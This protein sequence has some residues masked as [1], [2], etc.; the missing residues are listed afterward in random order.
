MTTV[1]VENAAEIAPPPEFGGD[2]VIWAMWLYYG[3]SRTQNEVAKTLG[4]SRASVANYL[5]EARRRG[6]VSISIAPNV[7]ERVTIARDLA[8]RTREI[9]ASAN[10]RANSGA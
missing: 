1:T 5:A 10:A 9:S 4:V 3:E 2:A 7:L 6:L 8:T